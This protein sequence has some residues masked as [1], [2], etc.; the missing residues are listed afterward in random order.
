[1]PTGVVLIRPSAVA[2][3]AA[4]SVAR[5]R[6]ARAEACHDVRSDLGGP[7]G[8][9]VDHRQLAHAQLDRGLRHCRA[10]AAGTHLHHPVQGCARQPAPEPLGE[11]GGIGVVADPAAAAQHHRVDRTQCGGVFRELVQERDHRLLTGKG[12]VQ[13]VEA[14][15]LGRGQQLGQ[16]LRIQAQLLQVD[17]AIDVAQALC[18]AFLLVHR[19]GERPLDAEADQAGQ[20]AP[21]LPGH[22]V[23]ALPSARYK[24]PLIAAAASRRS[25]FPDPN[26]SREPTG[27]EVRIPWIAITWQL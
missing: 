16:G 24:K 17:L 10:G 2:S 25:T 9:G 13:A 26:A 7:G 5:F 14:H 6:P 22:R 3:A 11:A 21:G 8:I 23:P 20:N 15:A 27:V 12:N 4:T 19:R 18:R 1:M